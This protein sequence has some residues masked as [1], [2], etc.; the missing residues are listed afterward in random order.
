[1]SEH[2]V[3]AIKTATKQAI[4]LN[5]KLDAA[6]TIVRVGRSQL[7]DYSSRN[8]QQ[9]VPVDVAIALD[10]GAEQPLILSAMAMAEGFMLVPVHAGAGDIAENA[11]QIAR[12]ATEVMAAT[13]RALADDGLV[14]A[15]EARDIRKELHALRHL[16]EIGLQ[17]TDAIIRAETPALVAVKQ[18]GAA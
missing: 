1:M 10:A 8:S 3:A 6:A 15:Q 7:S 5:G 18:E 14:D 9:V 17:R 12:R 13:M 11:E 4:E 2:I 16:T